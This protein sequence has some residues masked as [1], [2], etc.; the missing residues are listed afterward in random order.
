VLYSPEKGECGWILSIDGANISLCDVTAGYFRRPGAPLVA[1]DVTGEAERRYGSEEWREILTAALGSIDKRWL[2]PPAAILAAENKPRQLARALAVGFKIPQ[3]VVTNNFEEVRRF[4]AAGPSIAKP[5]RSALLDDPRDERI[6]F[7][8]RLAQLGPELRRSIE[9]V[10]LIVQ[11]EI[12]KSVDL[13]VTVVASAAFSTA[14]ES[15]SH[16]ET[17]VDWRKGGHLDL[18]HRIHHLPPDIS[19]KCVTL[20]KQF[21][22]RFSAIDLVLDRAGQYWFLEI[23]PNGQ[24]AWI[25]NRTGQPITGAIVDELE[26]IAAS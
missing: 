12:V 23:N 21:G 24:W 4:V 25:E 16:Q 18:V 11:R 2:N 9:V 22:L 19:Q 17:A 8:T 13:R 1:A 6:I 3:T 26:R 15:Q 14:I 20:T 10:P 7:T 5:I